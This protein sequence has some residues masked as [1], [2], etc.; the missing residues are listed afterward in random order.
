MGMTRVTGFEGIMRAAGMAVVTGALV[1]ATTGSP[2]LALSQAGSASPASAAAAASQAPTPPDGG[3]GMGAGG[4]G[5]PGGLPDDAGPGMGGGMG[6]AD[7]MSF[8][9]TGS[10]TG[11][12][13]A[14]GTDDASDGATVDA[15]QADENALL[16]ENG[17]T[18]AVTGATVTKEGD[19]AD[20]DSC[21]FYGLNSIGLAVGE[22]ST[23]T[24]SGST[25]SSTSEGSN[26]LFATDSGR[27]YATG[28]TIDTTG[29]NARG[30]DATYGGSIVASDLDVTTAGDHCAAAATDRGGG[31]VSVT[32]STL[33]TGG[34][35]SPLIYSTGDIEVSGVTGT[36]RESQIAGMEGLNTILVNDSTLTSTNTDTTGSDPVANAVIIYQSTSGD[37][38]S[39]TGEA[40]SFQ[41]A[42]STLASSIE[43]GSFFYLTNT[44]ADVV[45]AR[46]TLDYDSDAALLLYAAGN[47]AN[48]WGSAGSNGAT[49]TLTGIQQQLDGDVVADT[50]SSAT[51]Y[52][53]DGST[54]TGSASIED[55]DAGST[56]DA[57]IS[58]NVD[59]TSTW[60]VTEDATVTN[61]AVAE[62]A[63]VEDGQGRPVT[64]VA[65]G[66]TV[67]QGTSDVTVTVTGSYS[68]SYD[69]TGAGTLATETADRSGFDEAFST[70]T[71]FSMGDA[72]TAAS[73]GET[74][75][76]TGAEESEN[77]V[78]AFFS[79]IASAV[80]G[81]LAGLVG[82]R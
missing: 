29:D 8:D 16:A 14:D 35:G 68:T 39:A 10:Y 32:D 28:V 1:V 15:A 45:L 74:G 63:T 58:V 40:A 41:A 27:V 65:G 82:T 57:P 76:A 66:Q 17:G 34:S 12:V 62:G 67:R 77:P 43:S 53:T 59:A 42:D 33:E 73:S 70:Q 55:N 56:S 81:F 38:E 9:Y 4:E 37:A 52:L 75:T 30:L 44:T 19:D 46:T 20:G 24:V 49:V 6:G 22:G 48:N 64:I 60:V 23:L 36:A 13:T 80:G 26:A 47:D 2:A 79:A 71:A 51:L 78:V 50:I 3:P 54:W 11:V 31:T 7:T 21:N 18:L 69:A 5:Q 61:L 25:L 72:A